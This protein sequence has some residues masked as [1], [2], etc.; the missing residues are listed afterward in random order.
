MA[1]GFEDDWEYSARVFGL[2]DAPYVVV[3]YTMTSRSRDEAA[4]DVELVFEDLVAGMT[5]QPIPSNGYS[6]QSTIR[7][8]DTESF[9]GVDRLDAWG[10]F[11]REYL[12]RGLGDGFP[13]IAPTPEL[14][15]DFLEEV[16]RDPLEV[17][18]NLAPGY[19]VATVEKIAVNAA[20]A[21]ASLNTCPCWLPPFRRSPRRRSQY[22]Q[23][24][25]YRCQPVPTR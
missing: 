14:V 3:P 5:T 21:V 13:L 2:P 4:S 20:M 15:D 10:V 11:N 24:A 1:R 9:E 18:G 16:N 7:A 17:V 23:R 19:G 6:P 12:D 22:F 25:P 8:A